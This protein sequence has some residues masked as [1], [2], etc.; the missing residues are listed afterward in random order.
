MELEKLHEAAEKVEAILRLQT[1]PIAIKMPRRGDEIPAG[2]KMPLRDSGD[3]LS[4]CQ[5]FAASRRQ[6]LTMAQLKEDMWCPEPVLGFGLAEASDYFLEGNNRYPATARTAEAGRA[7]VVS[8]PAKAAEFEP[9]LIM[10]YGDSAQLTQLLN[11]KNWIDGRDVEC[12][13]SGHAA[14][15]YAVVPTLTTGQWQ[16]TAPCRGD[17]TRA[18]ARDDEMIVSFPAGDLQD[19]LAGLG[20]L[21]EHGHGLPLALSMKA[22]YPLAPSYVEIGRRAGMDWLTNA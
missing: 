22:E 8:A 14:C 15:V 18:L 5:I 11:V 1:Y 19:V 2:A 7:G 6:G 20:H 16:V 17:R 9:D 12:R 3:H 10:I 13:L 21:Q 4:T